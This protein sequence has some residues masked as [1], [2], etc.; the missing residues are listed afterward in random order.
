VGEA[1]AGEDLVRHLN[2]SK[3]SAS[4]LNEMTTVHQR[5]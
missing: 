4:V 5:L 3:I 1:P 2:S